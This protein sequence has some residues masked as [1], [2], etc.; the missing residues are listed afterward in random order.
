M[1]EEASGLR[2]A[3]S[4]RHQPLAIIRDEAQPPGM[5]PEDFRDPLMPM[6]AG[7][8]RAA[9]GERPANNGLPPRF[10]HHPQIL[11][12]NP[13]HGVD[14]TGIGRK[15]SGKDTGSMEGSAVAAA[16]LVPDVPSVVLSRGICVEASAPS[17]APIPTVSGATQ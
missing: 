9:G 3:P 1:R 6:S 16:G 8:P 7:H 2:K 15:R 17:S 4:A 12:P 5:A 10:L 11:P 13:Q 14:A